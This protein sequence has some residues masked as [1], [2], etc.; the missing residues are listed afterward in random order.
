[1]F[2]Y[3]ISIIVIVVAFG[4][5]FF[6]ISYKLKQKRLSQT[7]NLKILLIRLSQ[8][9]SKE[10]SKEGDAASWKDEINLSA[11]LFSIL[12]GLK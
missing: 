6:F 10:P 9:Q 3:L 1:M 8:K 11:Q 4:A 7:L 12:L 2:F 5:V